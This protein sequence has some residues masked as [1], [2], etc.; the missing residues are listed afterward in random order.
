MGHVKAAQA[1]YEELAK[2]D[3]DV[4]NIDLSNY[5][6][7]V[8]KQ[9]YQQGYL[10]LVTHVPML[11]SFLYHRVPPSTSK[12]RTF[13]DAINASKFRNF[14]SDFGPDM[15]V[16]THFIVTSLL[17]RWKYKYGF[18]YKII[19]VGTDYAAHRLW[20]DRKIDLYFAPT[21]L[22]KEQLQTMGAKGKIIVTGI[23]VG[24]SFVEKHEKTIVRLGLGLED[25]FTILLMNGGF[26]IGKSRDI[27]KN[28]IEI[29]WPVQVLAVAGQNQKL[30]LALGKVA[31]SSKKV[32]VSVFGFTN[33]IADLMTASD[34]IVSK[35]GGLTVAESLAV[36]T[37]L[38]AFEPTPGQEEENIRHLVENNSALSANN[39]EEIKS[40]IRYIR[41]GIINLSKLKENI[42]K[43]SSPDSA[44]QIADKIVQMLD[45]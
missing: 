11:Y 19:F 7:V 2:R 44:K 28:L 34:L 10:R 25:K 22:V 12:L 18:K 35:A 21:E 26:G 31:L 40:V 9:F 14:I 41:D 32:R 36:G 42:Q 16:S 38:L 39:I 3:V 6:T 37:P 1:I 27:L 24:S 5:C 45:G 4:K 8:S 13:F 15:I 29:D 43:I 20:L 30:K 17:S 23:P 33:Q